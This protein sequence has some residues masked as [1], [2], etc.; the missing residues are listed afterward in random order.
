MKETLVDMVRHVAPHFE[1]VKVT[2]T[3]S[4]TKIEAFTEDKDLFLVAHLKQPIPEFLGEFGIKDLSL[5][6]GLL[7]FSSYKTDEAKFKIHRTERDGNEFVAEFEFRDR[8]GSGTRFRTMSAKMVG[9]QAKIASITWDLTVTP[10]K[11]KVGEISQLASLLSKVDG[12]FGLKVENDTLYMTIG[13]N[14]EVTHAATIA[15]AEDVNSKL[16]NSSTWLYNTSNFLSILKNA[17]ND[18]STVSFCSRGVIAISIESA[19]GT[20]TYYIRGKQA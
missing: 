9:E 1:T 10:T 13:G 19:C 20:Y 3:E 4:D 18:S 5:L 16:L 8:N 12:M 2:G 6:K 11:A 7:E 15:L 17:G 14:S